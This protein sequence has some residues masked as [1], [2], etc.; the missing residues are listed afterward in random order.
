MRAAASQGGSEAWRKVWR[1]RGRS[2]PEGLREPGRTLCFTSERERGLPSGAPAC[3]PPRSA[4]GLA[5]LPSPGAPILGTANSLGIFFPL[6]STFGTQVSA[7][8]TFLP[9]AVA[10]PG[11]QTWPFEPKSANSLSLFP[12]P[13]RSGAQGCW[14]LR[15]PTARRTPLLRVQPEWFRVRAGRKPVLS[16]S[17]KEGR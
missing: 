4:G 14:G 15:V 5:C 3:P 6:C 7:P 8:G 1:K 17:L 13:A 10:V 11:A 9:G 12:G 2:S 16:P